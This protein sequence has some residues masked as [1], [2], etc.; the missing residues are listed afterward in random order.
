[1][2]L[3]IYLSLVS[4][5]VVVLLFIIQYFLV[6]ENKLKKEM[7]E[8]EI[9]TKEAIKRIVKKMLILKEEN[10]RLCS[11]SEIVSKLK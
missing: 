7:L 10:K 5:F 9:K 6:R 2:D 1:M 4:C 11:K 8:E 3:F